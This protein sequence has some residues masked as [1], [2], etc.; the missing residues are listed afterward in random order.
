MPR[1]INKAAPGWRQ[2]GTAANVSPTVLMN[3]CPARSPSNSSKGTVK[4]AA[5]GRNCPV[6]LK[7][8]H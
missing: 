7:G 3:S 2:F 4:L 1:K 6:N 8:A 5:K